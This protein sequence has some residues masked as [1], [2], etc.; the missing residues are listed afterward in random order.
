MEFD[1]M[2]NKISEL[3]AENQRLKQQLAK[4]TCNQPRIPISNKMNSAKAIGMSVLAMCAIIAL[5][6][7]E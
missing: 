1:Q 4:C 5:L 2:K 7:T 3:E 6:P